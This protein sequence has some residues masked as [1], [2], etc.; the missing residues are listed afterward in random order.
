MSLPSDALIANSKDSRTNDT[1][2]YSSDSR[3]NVASLADG[4][5]TNGMTYSQ[6]AATAETSKN[7]DSTYFSTSHVHRVPESLKRSCTFCRQ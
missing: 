7:E 3:L 2:P 4:D 5:L 6:L 1:S